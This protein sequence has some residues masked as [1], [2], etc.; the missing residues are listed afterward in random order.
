MMGT[1]LSHLL[2]VFD[3]TNLNDVLV[4]TNG[5]YDLFDEEMAEYKATYLLHTTIPTYDVVLACG[6]R[7]AGALSIPCPGIRWDSYSGTWQLGIP[8]P[9]GTNRW[10]NDANKRARGTTV[11]RKAWEL[12][13]EEVNGHR[14]LS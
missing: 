8:H 11:A 10:W 14:G 13:N 3:T 6:L 7:V 4:G 12:V 1:D 2:D 9:G 5:K